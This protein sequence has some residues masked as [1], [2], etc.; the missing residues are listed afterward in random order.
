[1]NRDYQTH[2]WD[3]LIA[4]TMK[5]NAVKEIYTE[6]TKDFEKIPELKVVN[7]FR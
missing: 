4:S 6:N 5:E 2:Y 1:M 3:Y 7:P